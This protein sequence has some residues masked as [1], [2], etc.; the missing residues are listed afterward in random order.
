MN[1]S[2]LWEIANLSWSY[3]NYTFNVWVKPTSTT[4]WQQIFWNANSY[5]NA[6]E[7]NV[8]INWNWTSYE[9]ASKQDFWFQ[10]RAWSWNYINLYWTQNRAINTWYNICVIWSSSGVKWYLN[11]T[12]IFSWSSSS[13]INLV[14]WW[15]CIWW[16][17]NRSQWTY[18]NFLT[19]YLSEFIF[20]N[21]NWSE[22]DLVKYV[23]KTKSKY[24]L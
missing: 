15:N 17:H 8:Y 23:N 2:T 1:G 20:E 10:Y 14:S 7:K 19:W 21:V 6:W 3:S 18:S 24:G 13:L 9:Q 16:A 22:S 11:W 12:L 4:V 5:N